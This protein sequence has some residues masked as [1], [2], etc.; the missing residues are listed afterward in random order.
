MSFPPPEN[1]NNQSFTF[2][3][4]PS[5][6]VF[7]SN[8]QNMTTALAFTD[9]AT[10]FSLTSTS[11]TATGTSTVQGGSCTLTIANSTY[12]IGTNRKRTE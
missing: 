2:S 9:D 5:G 10:Q 1:V 11:G 8:L 12:A 7:D 6:G 3:T 4:A